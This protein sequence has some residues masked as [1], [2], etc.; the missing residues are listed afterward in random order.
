M[1]HYPRRRH[2]PADIPF[3]ATVQFDIDAQVFADHWFKWEVGSRGDIAQ[4][5]GVGRFKLYDVGKQAAK[6]LRTIYT[7][8]KQHLRR[9]SATTYRDVMRSRSTGSK[10]HRRILSSTRYIRYPCRGGGGL[11]CCNSRFYQPRSFWLRPKQIR[12]C[13]FCHLFGGISNTGCS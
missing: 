11:C 4:I 2:Q 6:F 8:K 9:H 13:L 1:A 7:G 10:R 5:Q 12:R 3:A